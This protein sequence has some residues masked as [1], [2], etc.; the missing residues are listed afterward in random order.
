MSLVVEAG[1]EAGC[2]L[3][4]CTRI[5]VHQEV[6]IDEKA[7]EESA[8]YKRESIVGMNTKALRFID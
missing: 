7:P 8:P 4:N 1:L 3:R 2:A 6:A 5:D